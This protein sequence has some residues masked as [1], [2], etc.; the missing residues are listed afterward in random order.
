[1]MFW[2]TDSHRIP[3]SHLGKVNTIYLG[4]TNTPND[5][6]IL[7][8]S[9]IEVQQLESYIRVTSR[10]ENVFLSPA[11]VLLNAVSTTISRH[12]E[13]NRR[14]I[15]RR[16]RQ[17]RQI[18]L[19]MPMLRTQAGEVDFV[20]LRDTE[21]L[22]L[23]QIAGKLLDEA[24]GKARL[25][26]R[27]TDTNTKSSRLSQR[28]Q[29]LWHRI[30]LRWM[31][32]MTR[33]GFALANR[34]RLPDFK[35]SEVFNSSSAFVNQIEYPGCP[36]MSFFKPSCLPMNT[37]HLHVTMGPA[38]DAPVAVDGAVVVR[39]VASLSVRADHRIVDA[40]Q[41]ADFIRTLRGFLENPASIP[42]VINDAVSGHSEPAVAD[43][44]TNTC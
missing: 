6:T 2:P 34:I 15:G 28:A 37:C 3:L 27:S 7:W 24:H 38:H 39:K 43:V 18:N 10:R 19:T 23:K 11:H 32:C 42:D 25:V 8:G 36:P 16:V 1:M 30:Q 5:P 35:F 21:N 29:R 20:F 33:V 44:I 4:C 31:H 40:R 9:Q 41:I 22:S 13:F 26:L 14:I 17:L 12:P